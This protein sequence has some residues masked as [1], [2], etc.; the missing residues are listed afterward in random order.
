MVARR[1][2]L[3]DIEN[4]ACDAFDAHGVAREQ[5][6][7]YLEAVWRPGDFVT[8]ASNRRLWN[9][10]AWDVAVAHRYI[11]PPEGQDSA[12]QALLACA[13]GLDLSTF[14]SVVIGSG[15]HIFTDLAKTAA[16]QGSQVCVVANHGTIAQRLRSASDIV[17]ELPSAARVFSRPGSRSEPRRSLA[18]ERLPRRREHSYSNRRPRTPHRTWRPRPSHRPRHRNAGRSHPWRTRT[19]RTLQIRI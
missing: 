3:I 18:A 10:L 15:D 11:V 16:E 6:E 4:L 9:R 17:H 5:L 14:E 13:A 7:R 2:H 19:H 1:L 8:I 12:D